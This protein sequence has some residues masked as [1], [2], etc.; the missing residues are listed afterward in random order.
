MTYT[1]NAIAPRSQYAGTQ[2]Y[3]IPTFGSDLVLQLASGKLRLAR[4]SYEGLLLAINEG[5]VPC[6]TI[7]SIRDKL[8]S[9]R[10]TAKR[11][12][13]RETAHKAAAYA[14][15]LSAMVNGSSQADR[16]IFYIPE[17]MNIDDP[18]LSVARIVTRSIKNEIAQGGTLNE[19]VLKA[20]VREL[21]LQG[22][23]YVSTLT[24]D[25]IA[26]A[27]LLI[28]RINGK[29]DPTVLARTFIEVDGDPS[30]LEMLLVGK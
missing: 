25:N 12:G 15:N 30:K 5:S 27:Y 14:K 6:E 8:H 3:S 23:D 20:L 13:L 11:T 16:A 29:S 7:L 22:E 1:V 2:E 21:E 10:T 4:K 18:P 19:D 17:T 28:T 9:I 26:R 24:P